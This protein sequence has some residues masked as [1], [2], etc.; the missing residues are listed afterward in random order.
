MMS[1][2]QLRDFVAVV[3]HGGFRAAAIATAVTQGGLSKSVARLEDELG[4]Q[5]ITRRVDGTG[6]TP[7]GEKFLPYA[8]AILFEIDRADAWLST[9]KS[10]RR[11]S[12]HLGLSIE[13]SLQLAPK[14]LNHFREANPQVQVHLTQSVFSNLICAL[15]ENRIELALTLLPGD[16][17]ADDLEHS[18]IYEVEPAIVCR[19]GNPLAGARSMQEIA[20][21]DW[22]YLAGSFEE[23]L[24][25]ER[26]YRECKLGAPR[27]SAVSDSVFS[28][29]SILLDSNCLALLPHTIIHH[30]LMAKHLTRVS[31]EEP[32]HRHQIAIVKKASR[33]LSHEAA[34]LAAMIASLARILYP[35]RQDSAH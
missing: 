13:P 24:D 12:V 28:A 19:R 22:V 14:V 20:G 26:L 6:L 21:C 2:Q 27:V 17:S 18:V 25:I 5:L 11:K 1:I 30:P 35:K 16:H 31:I 4:L 34:M 7:D 8:R 29:V 10:E 32:P 3:S 9:Q 23:D 15:R 33:P